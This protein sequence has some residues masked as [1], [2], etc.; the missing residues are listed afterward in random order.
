MDAGSLITGEAQAK[1][2]ELIKDFDAK[3]QTGAGI[4]TPG[5]QNKDLAALGGGTTFDRQVEII[6]GMSEGQ[7]S[8][9][10]ADALL[11]QET[12]KSLVESMAL[13][14][15]TIDSVQKNH[16]SGEIP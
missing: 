3:I 7:Y 1:A 11:L 14:S 2:V 13:V 5:L 12:G 9:I 6:R 15:E 8:A 10:V 16:K 4:N